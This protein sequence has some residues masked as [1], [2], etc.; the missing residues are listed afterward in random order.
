M[1][2]CT[3]NLL[4]NPNNNQV[5]R[6]IVDGDEEDFVLGELA[7]LSGHTIIAGKKDGVFFPEGDFS[8]RGMA[9][10]DDDNEYKFLVEGL[11]GTANISVV[12]DEEF[13]NLVA[14]IGS[15]EKLYESTQDADE[16]MKVACLISYINDEG[17]NWSCEKCGRFIS[18]KELMKNLTTFCSACIDAQD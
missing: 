1:Q 16:K 18:T 8:I 14:L 15:L 6:I 4:V 2:Q 9:S 12:A 13:V 5:T 7:R 11:R 3:V 17:W 10:D